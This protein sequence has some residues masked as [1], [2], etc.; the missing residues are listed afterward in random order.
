MAIVSL[1]MLKPY[2]W[3]WFCSVDLASLSDGSN[4]PQIN[5]SDINPLPV[6]LP[7]LKEQEEIVR[8]LEMLLGLASSIEESA[9]SSVGQIERLSGSILAKAF[10]SEIVS[11]ESEL[12]QLEGR[13]YEPASVLLEHILSERAHQ[14]EPP[15]V[16][17]R[18]SNKSAALVRT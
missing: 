4:V 16:S 13:D 10:R 15:Q 9:E 7:P 12:A 17:K 11:T 1:H 8:R 3:W 5:H 6:P 2:H 18:K 14:T